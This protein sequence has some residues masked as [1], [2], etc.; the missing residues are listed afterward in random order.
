[1]EWLSVVSIDI[2]CDG[3]HAG[4]LCRGRIINFFVIE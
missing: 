1:M 3:R 2:V 4:E